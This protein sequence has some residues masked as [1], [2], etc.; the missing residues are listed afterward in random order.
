MRRTRLA[1]ILC[2]A[3]ASQGCSEFLRVWVHNN[4]GKPTMVLDARGEV[5]CHATISTPCLIDW[6]KRLQLNVGGQLVVYD[7]PRDVDPLRRE[8]YSE[9]NADGMRTADRR[10][11]GGQDVRLPDAS[12]QFCR[13]QS[14]IA[15]G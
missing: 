3:I 11:A 15:T 6:Q 13:W 9:T 12:F 1:F 4:T 7:A 14:M 10:D 5:L 2:G 8:P